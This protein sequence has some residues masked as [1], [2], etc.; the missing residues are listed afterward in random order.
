MKAVV[1]Y[2]SK[3]GFAERYAGWIGEE[4]H[5]DVVPFKEREKVSLAG[6]D[7]VIYGGGLHAGSI[8]GLKW[9]K[10]KLPELTGK[11]VAVFVTGAMPPE[12]PDV[13]KTL[14][15]NFTEKEW[16]QVKTFY[17]WGGLSYERMGFGDKLMMAVFRKMLKKMDKE[18]EALKMVS[19][20]YDC[21]SRE[22]ISPLLEYCNTKKDKE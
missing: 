10:K 20:S 15:Q 8:N 9:L 6:Y 3:T 12:G 7:T 22:Y 13:D 5:C 16:N 14:R 11:K 19:A 2:Y 17:L 18:G 21:T 1:I 4:L